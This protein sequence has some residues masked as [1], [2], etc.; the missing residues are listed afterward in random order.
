M[1][2]YLTSIKN[3]VLAYAS[4]EIQRDHEIARAYQMAKDN[5]AAAVQ[6]LDV[7]LDT[8]LK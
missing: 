8:L 2:E 6:W 3:D 7:R 4:Y 1:E 5:A